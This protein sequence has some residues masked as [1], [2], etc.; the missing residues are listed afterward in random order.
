MS[1][2]YSMTGFGRHQI[3]IQGNIYT[4][5][6]RAL[7]SGFAEI[8]IRLPLRLRSKEIEIRKIIAE[9]ALR[10]KIDF[11]VTYENHSGESN[12]V[13]NK[14]VFKAYFASIQALSNELNI[15]INDAFQ[16][17]LRFPEVLN[18]SSETINE[19]EWTAIQ[20]GIKQTIELLQQYRNTEGK[21][22]ANEFENSL[23]KIEEYKNNVK[24]LDTVRLEQVK[25]KIV[26]NLQQLQQENYD[27]NRLH[28]ELIYYAEKFDINEE[29]AR[30]TQHCHYFK[31]ILKNNHIQ[32][33]KQL[34][35]IVQE[36]GRE[37]NTIGSKA[38]NADIQKLV[39]QMKNE[40]DK[41]KEQTLN[42][43]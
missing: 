4:F 7:N 40:Q 22:I 39:V 21:S 2:I 25:Q 41:I 17:I 9:N 11:F 1:F 6:L 16:Y 23:Q 34:G 36:I 3:N 28:Q 27:A 31:E 37:I 10:G 29:L 38:N 43:L 32:K 24:S 5:E 18:Q 26:Q 35:F 14:S 42:I 30:L 19:D 13:I 8:N 20:N 12:Q 33:G 15:P